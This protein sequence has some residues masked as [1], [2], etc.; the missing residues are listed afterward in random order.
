MTPP[1][2]GIAAEHELYEAAAD[3]IAEYGPMACSYVAMEADERLE[4]GDVSGHDWWKR[5]MFAIGEMLA[6]R[7]PEGETIH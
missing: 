3:L 6:T 1:V 4:D 5:V 2:E 7:C